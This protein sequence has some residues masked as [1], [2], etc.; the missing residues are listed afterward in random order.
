MADYRARFKSIMD[1]SQPDPPGTALWN[2]ARDWGRSGHRI[3]AAMLFDEST[4]AM[5]RVWGLAVVHLAMGRGS[6]FDPPPK[7]KTEDELPF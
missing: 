1:G 5:W 4:P 6:W 2:L 3:D 7:P